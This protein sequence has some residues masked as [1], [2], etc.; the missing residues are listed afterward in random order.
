MRSI[1]N[2]SVMAPLYIIWTQLIAHLCHPKYPNTT[3][4]YYIH[5]RERGE[6]DTVSNGDD[7]VSRAY[8]SVMTDSNDVF[9]KLH[10]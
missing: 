6:S 8:E 10:G 9:E 7:T 3:T 5:R 1:K 2:D 4:P